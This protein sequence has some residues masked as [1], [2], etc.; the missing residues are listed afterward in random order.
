MTFCLLQLSLWESVVQCSVFSCTLL[1]VHSSFVIIL[2]GIREQVA[3]H[4]VFPILV[5][6]DGYVALPRG[7]MSLPA[8]CDCGISRSYSLTMFAGQT[9]K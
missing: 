8:V 4:I 5:S 1:Y 6:R 7:V 2:M 9:M 3:L